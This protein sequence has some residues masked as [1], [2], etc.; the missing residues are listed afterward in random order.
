[1]L[2]NKITKCISFVRVFAGIG[3]VFLLFSFSG[4]NVR[5]SIEDNSDYVD[6]DIDDFYSSSRSIDITDVSRR[7]ITTEGIYIRS[8]SNSYSSICIPYSKF[9]KYQYLTVKANADYA[10]R[11]HI[12]KEKPKKHDGPVLYSDFFGESILIRKGIQLDIVIPAD[13]R[14]IVILNSTDG[15]NNTPDH[16][17]LNKSKLHFEVLDSPHLDKTEHSYKFLHWN[18]GHFSNGQYPYSDI[19]EENYDIRLEGYRRFLSSFGSDCNYL[20]NEYD[21][22]FATVNDSLISTAKVLFNDRKPYMEFPRNGSSAFNKL[23]AFW[24]GDGFI[25]YEYNVFESLKGVKNR[26]GTLQYGIGYCISRF[27]FGKKS[28]YVMSLHVPNKI[29]GKE[30]DALYKEILSICSD[31]DNCILVG[32]FN[33][34]VATNFSVLTDAGF[35]IL[36]DDI[37]TYPNEG[38]ILDWVLYRCNDMVLSDFKVYSEAIDSNGD[39]LSDHLPLG[40]TVMCNNI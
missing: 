13:A 22:T 27:A 35:S 36:N 12:L 19:S 14:F 20:L 9:R 4:N 25:G 26:N 10:T 40:F 15:H 39:L 16:V 5:L 11:I 1:M 31:Y 2:K 21:E 24:W 29:S 38:Y 37:V 17:T 7:F 23:A 30:H 28:L 34:A 33:R 8:D 18:I 6:N 32:D 3:V